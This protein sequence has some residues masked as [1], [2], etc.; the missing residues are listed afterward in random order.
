MNPHVISDDWR[1]RPL[2]SVVK[3][4]AKRKGINDA[5]KSS[6]T[7]YSLVLMVIHYL[8][9]TF[10]HGCF[11]EKSSVFQAAPHQKCFRTCSKS[12]LP[13]SRTSATSVP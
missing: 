6:F 9:C 2:V 8:Q 12:T 3:E 5:N 10:S 4:W 11:L 7:S 13:V 1:V